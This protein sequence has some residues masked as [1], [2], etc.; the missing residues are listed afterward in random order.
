[1]LFFPGDGELRVVAADRAIDLG[2]ALGDCRAAVRLGM[3]RNAV[4]GV[5]GDL[6]GG[7]GIGTLHHHDHPLAAGAVDVPVLV[8]ITGEEVTEIHGI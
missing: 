4:I 6:H 8:G 3:Q 2:D 5:A 7:A 1:M